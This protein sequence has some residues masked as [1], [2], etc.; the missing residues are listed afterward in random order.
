MNPYSK[1]FSGGVYGKKSSTIFCL[2]KKYYVSQDDQVTKVGS[3]C[4]F[5][6]VGQGGQVDLDGQDGHINPIVRMDG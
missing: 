4:H 5:H 6:R 3:N 1:I 2:L